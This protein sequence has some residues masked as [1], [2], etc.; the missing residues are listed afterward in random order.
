MNGP[1]AIAQQFNL[2]KLREITTLI[3]FDE[4]HKYERWKSF[5][6][7]FFDTYR[8]QVRIIVTGSAKL[9][10]YRASGDS[11]MGRYFPY[12]IHPLSVAECVRTTLPTTEIHSPIKIKNEFSISIKF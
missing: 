8:E 9:D 10:I 2:Q 5:V 12:R 3:I 4:I 11:M 7:G 1:E 6:K